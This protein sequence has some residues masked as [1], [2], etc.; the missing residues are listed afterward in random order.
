MRGL[1]RITRLIGLLLLI[2]VLCGAGIALYFDERSRE[3]TKYVVGSAKAA[4]RIDLDVTV[5]TVDATDGDLVLRVLPE[6]NGTLA[7]ATDNPTRNLVIDLTSSTT[8]ELRFPAGQPIA[9]HSV[10][11]DIQNSGIVTDYPF[12][13]YT[14]VLVFSVTAGGRDVPVRMSLREVDPFFVTRLRGR[15]ATPGVVLADIRISRSRGTFILAWFMMI[16]MWA[17]ALSVLGGAWILGARRQGVVWPALGWM[18]ATLFAL[19]GMR[20]AAPGAPPI[21][22]LI[23]YASFFWAEAIVAA[24]LTYVA[25]TGIRAERAA[26]RSQTRP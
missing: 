5:Q 13:H 11:V 9:V 3:E 14:T 23:D 6:P 15:S 24:S 12:D 8:P 25:V 21:G 16:A 1:P 22:S 7:T 20:N 26:I 10:R 18:A 17:L 19:I 4:N 2:A